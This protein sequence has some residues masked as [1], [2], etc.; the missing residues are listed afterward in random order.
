MK[1][2]KT[3]QEGHESK[4][5]YHCYFNST[6]PELNIGIALGIY[7][8]LNGKLASNSSSF[9]FPAS[10]Q[11]H[12]Y[13][14]ILSKVVSENEGSFNQ[15]GVSV[16]SIGTHSARKGAATL[17]AS[18]CTVS[19][20]MSSIC[21]RAGWTLGGTR[22]KYIKYEN[23]QDQFL[24]R[25][26]CGFNVLSEGFSNSPPFF[27]TTV[28]EMIH[29]D[30]QLKSIIPESNRM[31]PSFF[32]VVRSCYASIVYHYDWIDATLHP[33]H[34]FRSHPAFTCIDTVS[35]FFLFLFFFT[36]TT[37]VF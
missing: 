8:F 21:N 35:Y 30:S 22:D 29:I 2:S 14:D 17:A 19:P 32:E 1:K 33:K 12:R 36:V 23:A 11:Y 15:I 10:N 7:L 27:D 24:G 20:S 4:T 18:G 5:P 9:L 28:E 6:D 16:G 37:N 13:S 3:D 34:R 25:V 26:L 31:E